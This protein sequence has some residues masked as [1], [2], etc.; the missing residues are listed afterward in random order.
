[1]SPL[2]RRQFGQ[3]AA[4]SLT[5][6]VVAGLSSKSLAEKS[7][8]RRDIIYTVNLSR[9]SKVQNRENQ[10]PPVEL[11]TVELSTVESRTVESRTLNPNANETATERVIT[12]TTREPLSV[13]N[14][15]PVKKQRRAFFL[16][17][18][19]RITKLISLADKSLVICTVS[20]TQEGYFSHLLF[21]I[22]SGNNPQFRAKKVLGLERAN[23]TIE[24]LLSLPKNQ[25]LCLV[26]NEGTPP[27][28]FRIIDTNSGKILSADE[29]DLPSLQYNHRFANLCQ[30][31]KGTI[32]ATEIGS[33]G[34]PILISMNLQEK[35]TLTGKVKINRRAPLTFN[36]RPLFNDVK[37]LGFSRSGQ[38]YA[39]AADNS[40]KNNAL[41]TVDVKTGAMSLVKK[42]ASDKFAF[43][44]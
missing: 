30:D 17:D 4:A 2:K 20:S 28:M 43:A 14:P 38:L 33:E 35:A 40:G 1:M 18:S 13:D 19:D 15:S 27:F 29:L 6:T 36:K 22:G 34:V 31:Q 23:Q 41:F 42:F 21:A 7:E 16:P 8:L 5:S 39:L 10:T 32:F 3:L 37:D 44:R 26:G 24:S 25:L 12:K 11:S 9:A